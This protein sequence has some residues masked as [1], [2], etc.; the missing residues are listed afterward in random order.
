MPEKLSFWAKYLASSFQPRPPYCT[1]S[2]SIRLAFDLCIECLE[3]RPPI[4]IKA[5][6]SW[7]HPLHMRVLA[8]FM[9]KAK[10]FLHQATTM[11]LYVATIRRLLLS[12]T[13]PQRSITLGSFISTDAGG[14]SLLTTTCRHID[15]DQMMKRPNGT[16]LLLR[17][18]CVTGTLRDECGTNPTSNSVESLGRFQ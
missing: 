14:E 10:S 15:Y 16:W 2:K 9:K 17:P 4:A 11:R 6:K 13:A 1:K 5:N 8:D 18:R 12:L 3:N 7:L